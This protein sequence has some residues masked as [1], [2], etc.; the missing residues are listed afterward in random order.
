MAKEINEE[1]SYKDFTQKNLGFLHPAKFDNTRVV[2]SAFF[3]DFPGSRV[4]PSGMTGVEFCGGGLDNV[5][6]PPGNIILAADHPDN[7]TGIQAQNRRMQM[8]NDS[9][10]WIVDERGEPIEPANIE[11]V[12]KDGENIDPAKIPEKYYR[13]ITIFGDEWDE[14]FEK[15]II[16][17]NSI[18]REIPSII[19]QKD[20]EVSVQEFKV[21]KRVCKIRGEAWLYIGQKEGK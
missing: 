2:G 17:E 15:G 16:P 11:S 1:F 4:F 19:E 21:I 20:V 10:Y 14:T 6:L 3:Q 13:E 8:Q 12:L 9:Q 7:P 5:D 18:F